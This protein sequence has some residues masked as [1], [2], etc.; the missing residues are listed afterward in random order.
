MALANDEL[1]GKKVVI[2][3]VGMR[4]IS[5][6]IVD[7]TKY[8]VTI[9]TQRSEKRVLKKGAVFDFED[10]GKKVRIDGDAIIAKPE[11]RI[12]LKVK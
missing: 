7:E 6:T 1:I 2:S 10:N 3:R 9:K 12:M 11:E 8:T 5:G 4:C